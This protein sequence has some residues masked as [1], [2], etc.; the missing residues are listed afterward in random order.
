MI[1]KQEKI[2]KR[3]KSFRKR[4]LEQGKVSREEITHPRTIMGIC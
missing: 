2:L 1:R 4:L 3:M